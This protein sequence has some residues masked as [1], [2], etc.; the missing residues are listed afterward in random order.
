MPLTDEQRLNLKRVTESW[1]GTPYRG[2]SA[3]KGK[4]GGTDCGQL[5]KAVYIE[6]GHRPED[7]IPIAKDYSLQIW[8]H[9]N[10]TTYIDTVE[11]Y[12]REIPESEAKMGDLVLYK[13]GRGFA[14]AAIIIDWP[15]HVVHANERDGVVAGHGGNGEFSRN[16]KFSR[17]EKRF[18][19][20][21][22]EFCEVKK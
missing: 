14:H 18:Y 11:K 22:D 5:V 12:M 20:V 3:V 8:H 16:L 2:W 19:T 15:E 17:L 6:A 10:D 9:K 1:Y 7:G 21:K 4:K 13:F